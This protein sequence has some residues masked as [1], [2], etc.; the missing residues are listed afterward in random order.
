VDDAV[1]GDDGQREEI[2]GL[3]RDAAVPKA[4]DG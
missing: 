2:F 4:N 1:Q 3:F